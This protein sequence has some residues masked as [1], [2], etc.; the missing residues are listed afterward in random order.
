M[1][2]KGGKMNFIQET[3]LE[4]EFFCQEHGLK[5]RGKP[6]ILF[7][8]EHAPICPLCEK[9]YDEQKEREE[10]KMQDEIKI[11]RFGK[12]NI[13]PM[14]FDKKISDYL[15]ENESQVKAK[16]A[17]E[18]IISG[19]LKELILLGNNGLGKTLLGSIAVQAVSGGAIYS[20]YEIG[21]LVRG[22]YNDSNEFETLD[23]L[24]RLPILVID[25]YEKCKTSKASNDMFSYILD[26]RHSRS[27]RTI[28]LS[29]YH[30]RKSCEKGGCD[31]CFESVLTNDLISRFRQNGEIIEM[32][33]EDYR[34][35]LRG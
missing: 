1:E 27:L 3:D 16:N 9:K 7:G 33:G 18:K 20:A 26:K 12:M 4:Q 32:C 14:Y 15:P 21:L 10:K 6:F 30:L 2:Q 5:Y 13:E 35:R 28:L 8:V 29:N 17:V 34:R 25:E 11:Q 19:E 22:S 24:A 23:R 31:E